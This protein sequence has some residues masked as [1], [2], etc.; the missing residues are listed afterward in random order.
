LIGPTTV[1]DLVGGAV[2]RLASPFVGIPPEASAS[3][4]EVARQIRLRPAFG[5][6]ALLLQPGAR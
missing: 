4:A 2:D 5:G 1:R 3:S 6:D